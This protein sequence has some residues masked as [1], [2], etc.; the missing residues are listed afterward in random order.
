MGTKSEGSDDSDAAPIPESWPPEDPADAKRRV[1]PLFALPHVWL[2]PYVILPLHIFEERYKGMI[3]DILDGPGRIVL[4]TVQEGFEDD[5]EGAPPVYPIG[6]LGEIGRHEELPDGRFNILLVGLQRVRITEIECQT[7]YRQVEI[8]PVA[9]IPVPV[10][11]EQDLR[12]RLLA[13]ILERTDEVVS[14]PPQVSVSHLADLLTLRMP[15]PHDALNALYSELDEEK[16]AEMALREHGLR[17]KLEPE[18]GE[19]EGT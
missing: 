15:L 1:V 10:G 2:F 19:G 4:G 9:D 8:E 5:V 16:R 11:R 18:E 12:S 3:R 14:I 6:G 17:P 7:P 13:A